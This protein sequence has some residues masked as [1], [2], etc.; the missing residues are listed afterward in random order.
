[1]YAVDVVG[2]AQFNI[3]EAKTHLSR[4]VERVRTGEEI[5]IARHGEP[6]AKLVPYS[7]VEPRVRGSIDP[8]PRLPRGRL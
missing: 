7:Y 8:R 2:L 3:V 4:L 6:Q 1:M 5:V